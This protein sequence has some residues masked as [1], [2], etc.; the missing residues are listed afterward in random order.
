MIRFCL[1]LLGLVALVS[2]FAALVVDGTR[3]IAGD[4]LDLT[5]LGRTLMW[6]VPNLFRT[7]GPA[8]QHIHPMLWDPVTLDILRI[9]TWAFMFFLGLLLMRLG[10]KPERKIGFTSRP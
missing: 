7:L 10:R 6:M 8:M 3:S 1:R 9:P 2:G 4:A 5:P